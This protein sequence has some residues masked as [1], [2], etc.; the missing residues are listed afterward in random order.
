MFSVYKATTAGHTVYFYVT[1][2]WFSSDFDSIEQLVDVG[3]DDQDK[4]PT[5]SH[6]GFDNLFKLL[7][8]ESD[9]M[10][11]FDIDKLEN[12]YKEYPEWLM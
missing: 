6:G 11:L 3:L 5:D 2:E 4:I 12:I 1:P 7:N 10:H 9:T 8:D